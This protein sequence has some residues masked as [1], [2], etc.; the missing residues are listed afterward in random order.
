MIGEFIRS[1]RAGGE[2]DDSGLGIGETKLLGLGDTGV[3]AFI[4][5]G[6]FV[7]GITRLTNEE[8]RVVGRSTWESPAQGESGGE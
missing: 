8:G 3:T 2:T 5:L 1:L 7:L 4:G 6:V